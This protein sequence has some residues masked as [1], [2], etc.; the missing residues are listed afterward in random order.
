[1]TDEKNHDD[2]TIPET[3]Q[4]AHARVKALE[5]QLAATQRAKAEND[6]RF[7]LERDHAIHVMREMAR[8]LGI[9]GT[10][11]AAI[12]EEFGQ[13]PFTVDRWGALPK[14]DKDVAAHLLASFPRCFRVNFDY[15]DQGDWELHLDGDAIME[16]A[17]PSGDDP[18]H[19][20]TVDEGEALLYIA[21]AEA[22]RRL[23]SLE[24]ER[25]AL[26]EGMRT[27][28]RLIPRGARFPTGDVPGDAL[29]RIA[30]IA[31]ERANVRDLPT[32]PEA[33]IALVRVAMGIRMRDHDMRTERPTA[34]EVDGMRLLQRIESWQ[35]PRVLVCDRSNA[36]HIFVTCVAVGSFDPQKGSF[37]PSAVGE[38]NAM[39][40]AIA[41]GGNGLVEGQCMPWRS[42][43]QW[44][45][46]GSA[47]Q[48]AWSALEQ[49][50]DEVRER[51]ERQAATER[52]MRGA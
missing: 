38:G 45:P 13:R 3:L 24:R 6:E 47:G 5:R 8:S 11:S 28:E 42:D 12:I 34:A 39:T 1:M 30:R 51:R 27:L 17:D 25:D 20:V 37:A 21:A 48:A 4:E 18:G 43:Y 44:A 14:L 50:T 15:N 33:I 41:L 31:A 29:S 46:L 52:V 36:M 16:D 35:A 49:A 26:S 10:S 2:H 23:I 40:M 32:D 19:P 9:K 7:M 22:L